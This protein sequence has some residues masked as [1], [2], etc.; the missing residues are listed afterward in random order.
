MH[1]SNPKK[2]QVFLYSFIALPLA[3]AGLP[4][5]IHT[6]DFYVRNFSINLG[7][8][9][10]I[11]LFIRFI[12]AVQDPIIGYLSDRFSAYRFKIMF[13][14]SLLLFIGL[15]AVC[16]GPQ[17]NISSGLWFFI[18][19]VIAS[20]G[21]SIISINLNL[22]GGLWSKEPHQRTRISA[23]REVFA[24]FGLILAAILPSLLTSYFSLE[25]SFEVL[26]WIFGIFIF[27]GI[28][29]FSYFIS[30]NSISHV[31]KSPTINVSPY[32]FKILFG[33]NKNFFL[34][35]FFCYLASSVASVTV[36]FFIRDY[37]KSEELSGFFLLLYFLSGSLFMGIWI[38]LSINIGKKQAWLYSMII[39]IVIFIWTYFLSPGDIIAYAVICVISG[40]MLG[41][42]LALPPSI[43]ADYIT[44]QKKE[45]L[46]AQF[47]GVLA[48]IPK[49]AISI[50]SCLAFLFLS[51]IQFVSGQRN[52]VLALDRLV[53]IYSVFPCVIKVLSAGTLFYLCKVEGKLNEKLKNNN[54]IGGYNDT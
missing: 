19:M 3:F 15:G 54:I 1:N 30:N 42:D 33:K 47:Y 50:S 53:L 23:M 20:S 40:G 7:V 28:V 52:S 12:D 51:D 38:K 2:S 10:I 48:F 22:V 39:S 29:F 11:L 43:L 44:N 49:I 46:A 27:F 18:S 14:G 8:I 4:L 34:I 21:F 17:K 35:C 31:A 5:Y 37:L 13:L 24:L 25:K 45:E 9:G 41:A 26:F 32:F 6:P 36:L 16:Y